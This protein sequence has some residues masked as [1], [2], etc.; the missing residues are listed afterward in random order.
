M[1][2]RNLILVA[3]GLFLGAFVFLSLQVTQPPYWG[4]ALDLDILARGKS[5]IPT[6]H[7]PIWLIL[8]SLW[9]AVPSGVAW[10]SAFCGAAA[11]ALAFWVV[12]SFNHDRFDL[13][14]AWLDRRGNRSVL[15]Q[16]APAL[17]VSFLLLFHPIFIQE[18][19][20]PSVLPFHLMW[21]FG[22]VLLTQYMD[23]ESPLWRW[24]LFCFL[25]G[26]GMVE[27][28]GFWIAFPFVFL[29]LLVKQWVRV[30]EARFWLMGLV[31]LFFGIS[32]F[33]WRPLYAVTFTPD[34]VKLVGEWGDIIWAQ[35]LLLREYLRAAPLYVWLIPGAF[36]F[37]PLVTVLFRW[38]DS[39][40]GWLQNLFLL[41]FCWYGTI[42]TML[43]LSGFLYVGNLKDLFFYLPSQELPIFGASLALGY[44]LGFWMIL[45]DGGFRSP[46][47]EP[48]EGVK[49]GLP[50]Y[51]LTF[52]MPGIIIITL[53][54]APLNRFSKR[55][56]ELSQLVKSSIEALPPKSFIVTSQPQWAHVF[57]TSLAADGKSFIVLP[58]S[59][60]SLRGV[61]EFLFKRYPDWFI[62]KPLD[63]APDEILE[64]L[65]PDV[66]IWTNLEDAPLPSNQYRVTPGRFLSRIARVDVP[67]EDSAKVVEWWHSVANQI[68]AVN[69]KVSEE[70]MTVRTAASRSAN[71]Y[72]DYRW[73]NRASAE[74][75]DAI[76]G[77]ALKILPVN[78]SVIGNREIL[79]KQQKKEDEAKKLHEQLV[80]VVRK[81]GMN[82]DPNSWVSKCGWLH[83][84]DALVRR[85]E[86][87]VNREQW[88]LAVQRLIEAQMAGVPRTV[89]AVFEMSLL[90]TTQ[91]PEEARVLGEA[92]LKQIPAKQ[93]VQLSFIHRQTARAYIMLKKW[94]EAE[95]H[96][97][98]GDQLDPTWKKSNLLWGELF[99]GLGKAKE[100]EER[101]TQYHHDNP[102]DMS[103]LIALA[104]L[105]AAKGDAQKA[106]DLMDSNPPRPSDRSAWLLARATLDYQ[107]GRF[108]EA[109]TRILRIPP[110]TRTAPQVQELLRNCEMKLQK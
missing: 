48:L 4:T 88:P 10:S 59:H 44:L 42:A 74:E 100:S 39:D 12:F 86:L 47:A 62:S 1:S 46:Q 83:T 15:F 106:A 96:L 101:L 103:G 93:V 68:G 78:P 98:A 17:T 21:L 67:A 57:S 65:R 89:T 19:S 7:Y 31:W 23:G 87:A 56:N 85:L 25:Y 107:L 71:E 60:L 82:P 38:H 52:V 37:A 54:F 66:S 20:K 16:L 58:A 61:H 109:K 104:K 77:D 8:A 75:V 63:S 69:Q 43:Y 13:E 35:P 108:S 32:G 34:E 28:V 76:L 97:T 64:S 94:K 91:H 55:G 24:G 5:L 30:R 22:M 92:V 41:T 90:L 70:A 18:C 95:A 84:P 53:L 11:V 99:L 6:L 73:W 27:M 105:F 102:Q 50:T 29:Y 72:A 3:A 49:L 40:G 14:R 26:M 81:M 80:E 9:T 110:I 51:I 33:F 45:G 2:T 36:C 79:R